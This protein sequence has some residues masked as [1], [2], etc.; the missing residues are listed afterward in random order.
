MGGACGMFEQEGRCIVGLVGR[1]E[2]QKPLGRTSHTLDNSNITLDLKLWTGLM[3]LR[4][5]TSGGGLL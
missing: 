2:G 4:R 3:W 1:A 5:R